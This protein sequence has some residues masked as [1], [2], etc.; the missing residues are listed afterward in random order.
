MRVIGPEGVEGVTAAE[1]ALLR[2]PIPTQIVSSDEYLPAPQTT[3]QREVEARLRELGSR[4]A[5]R[6]GISR[7][8]FFATAAGMAASYQVMN[9]VYGELFAVHPA[10][11][12]DPELAQARAKGL[13]DQTIFDAHVHFIRD[14]PSPAV[15]D[16][17]R[18]GGLM[19]QRSQ[20]T[21]LGWNKDLVGRE[22]TIADLKYDNFFK[23]IYLDSDTKV[24]LLTNAPSDAPEDW[25]LP[26][27]AVFAARDKVNREA[28]AKRLLA[29]Y[30]LTP[31]QPGWLD[32]V[33]R[34]VEVLKPDGWK[35]YTIGDLILTHGG[36]TAWRMDDEKLMYPFYEKAVKAGIRTVCVHKGLFPLFAEQRIPRLRDFAAVGDVG[37][38][39]K[40]WPQ[41]N[42]AIY[43][44]GFRHLGGP[45]A[46]GMDEW[47]QTGR[48]SWLSDLA[49]IPGKYGVTN[50]YGD[51]GAI[52]AWT[53]IAQPRLAAA[54]MGTLI[55]GLGADRV[56]WG[57]DSV[58]TGSPQWQIEAM[59]RLEIPEDMQAA[60]GFKPLGPADGPVKKAIFADNGLR[61]FGYKKEAELMRPDR[62]TLMKAEYERNGASP[63]NLRYGYMRRPA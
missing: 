45:P 53:V 5:A 61:L 21:K 1:E 16:A 23:E 6:Q 28:G 59:R 31:G 13:A 19:W 11:A 14:D 63:S 40:D 41:L 27:D 15:S 25:L 18:I 46:D 35:G 51:L 43:H 42:F 34:A 57:T 17:S 60:H 62:F 37:K 32:G 7:R 24:A 33:D 8:R 9:Q 44:S 26:Q 52:F 29:H 3:Q 20:V 54:M 48:M 36:R 47:N 22:P 50:V 55:K 39:A 12:A 56:I 2:A 4:L 38:A 58:W 30:T 49:D 10:E